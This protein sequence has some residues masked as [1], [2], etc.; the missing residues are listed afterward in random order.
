L[1]SGE[2][3]SRVKVSEQHQHQ[4]EAV[5]HLLRWRRWDENLRL[6]WKESVKGHRHFDQD[7]DTPARSRHR[8]EERRQDERKREEERGRE[9]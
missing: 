9:Q 8:G 4:G 3:D 5:V 1:E 7:F 2:Y 6:V